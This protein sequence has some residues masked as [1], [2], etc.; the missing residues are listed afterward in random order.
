MLSHIVFGT[1]TFHHIVFNHIC[2]TNTHTAV[3]SYSVHV[4]TLGGGVWPYNVFD[5]KP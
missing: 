2:P 4:T 1:C 3:E 5:V